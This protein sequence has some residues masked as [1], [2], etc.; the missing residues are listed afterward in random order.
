MALSKKKVQPDGVATEYHRVVRVDVMTNVRDL[1]EVAS[2]VSAESRAA[3]EASAED[4]A[5]QYV[6]TSFYELPYDQSTTVESAYA[7]LKTL[8]EFE[9]A[10][11]VPEG[12]GADHGE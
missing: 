5:Q 9:G 7:Y 3:A 1:V 11:D 4:G 8:P 10:S 6:A 12:G 2:Y